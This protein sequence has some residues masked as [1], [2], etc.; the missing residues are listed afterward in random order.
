MPTHHLRQTAESF[1]VDAARYDRTRPP[2][3][4]ALLR[5]I[6]DRSPGRAV[7]NAGC[8]TGIESRQLREL[9]CTVLGVE[10]D[11]RMADVARSTGIAVEVATFEDWE[12]G[13]RE[14][15]LVVAGTA[16]HW[17]DPVAGAAKAAAVLRPGG[18][19]APFWHTFQL[20]DELAAGFAEA[21]RRLLPDSP[22][23]FGQT[24]AASALDGYRPILDRAAEGIRAAGGFGEPEVWHVDWERVYSR[25]DYLDQ[26]PTSGALTRATPAQLAEIQEAVGAVIDRLG[27]SF[28]MRYTS[29]A[30]TAAR[31]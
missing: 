15:D 21:Y 5:R 30:V 25:D 19:L 6:V 24:P 14:F 4:V 26:L 3:P 9:G 17:I 20:P 22:F 12:P 27:G 23:Q 8:G 28:V 18:R 31:D 11:P 29:A 2:Y 7:L 1:G 16:W 13:G 10:P